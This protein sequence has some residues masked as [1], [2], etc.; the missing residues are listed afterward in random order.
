MRAPSAA[1]ARNVTRTADFPL[2]YQAATASGMPAIVHVKYDAEAI[3]PGQT[4]SGIRAAA[5]AARGS[6]G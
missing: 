6:V 1:S 2:A 3:T 4:L 5:L